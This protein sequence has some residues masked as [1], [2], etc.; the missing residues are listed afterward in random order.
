MSFYHFLVLNSS[1]FNLHSIFG[2]VPDVGL[3]AFFQAD[4]LLISS[5]L[6]PDK[7][8]VDLKITYQ[9]NPDKVLASI[10][11]QSE[12]FIRTRTLSGLTLL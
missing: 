11:C 7:L 9:S 2:G 10:L 6:R 1:K 4:T 5:S 12:D 3:R 8:V